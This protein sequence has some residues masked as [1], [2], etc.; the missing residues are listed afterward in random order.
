M[1]NG[2]EQLVVMISIR[3]LCKAMKCIDFSDD[4]MIHDL[5][6]LVALISIMT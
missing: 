3:K 2:L 5:E 1:K 4:T 6:Q